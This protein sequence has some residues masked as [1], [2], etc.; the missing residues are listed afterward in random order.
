MK[1]TLGIK[2]TFLSK[3]MKPPK[4]PE[5]DQ[6][7]QAKHELSEGCASYAFGKTDAHASS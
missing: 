1:V 2:V 4:K 3:S 7:P 5:P 6:L